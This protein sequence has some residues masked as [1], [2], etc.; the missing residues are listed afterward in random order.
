MKKYITIVI[1]IL[2][3]GWLIG[4]TS[5]SNPK[6]KNRSAGINSVE[7]IS[8]TDR[9]S[10]SFATSDDISWNDIMRMDSAG[11][12][13][14]YLSL[15]D[16]LP[17][18]W[19]TR[20]V[21]AMS[22]AVEDSIPSFASN[23]VVYLYYRQKVNGY[24]VWV[25]FDRSFEQMRGQAGFSIY[26]GRAIL[27]FSMPQHSFDVYCEEFSDEAL[28]VWDLTDTT[29]Y[30]KKRGIIDLSKLKGGETVH[31]DYIRP[32]E[33]EYLSDSSPF[34]FKDMDYDGEKEL[35]VNNIAMGCRGYNTYDVFKVFHGS[36]PLRLVGLPFTDQSFKITNYNVEYEPSN[37]CVLDKRY[38]GFDAYGHYRY[39]SV[40]VNTKKG[41]RRAFI[42]I[43]S[44]DMGFYHL[45]NSQPS[46]TVVLIQP[47]KKYERIDGKIIMSEKGVY[48]IGCY[49][50]NYN[51]VIL[52]HETKYH[53]EE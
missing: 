25:E 43:D 48:E 23:G 9:A 32:K 17:D 13:T 42:L 27:H 46:D 41:Q 47:F 12:R 45:N 21:Y 14:F 4:N 29:F 20:D 22:G 10:G 38:D 6:E 44:E 26:V 8:D 35:V 40:L 49:G 30:K 34:Y 52:H 37:K 33:G 36:K 53:Q 3:F 15:I 16:S 31:L 7:H 50:Q 18:L 39:Q 1:L 28:K 11:K 51:R 19:M 5:C 24:R 2:L